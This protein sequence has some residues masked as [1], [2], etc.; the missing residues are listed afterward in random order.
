MIA[1][2]YAR[3]VGRVAMRFRLNGWQRIGIVL[4]VVWMLVGALWAH[5]FLFAPVYEAD[6][7]CRSAVTDLTFC[8]GIYKRQMAIARQISPTIT[9]LTLAPIPIVWVLAYA[10]VSLVRWI[11]AGFKRE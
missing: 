6:S 1:G 7:K 9:V 10:L 5:H 2:C 11:R 4:S 8:D 3:R